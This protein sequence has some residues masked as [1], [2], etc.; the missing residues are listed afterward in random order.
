MATPMTSRPQYRRRQR[1]PD[2]MLL[3]WSRSAEGCGSADT[4]R[5]Q[6]RQKLTPG[7]RAAPQFGHVVTEMVM[8]QAPGD[9]QLASALRRNLARGRLEEGVR[10]SV[11]RFGRTSSRRT[12]A[13]VG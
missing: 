7:F 8:V 10:E 1:G 13:V 4:G 2:R 3:L 11:R 9:R 12:A 6:R 5:P